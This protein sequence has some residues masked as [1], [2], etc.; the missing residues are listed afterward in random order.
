MK[1]IFQL[2]TLVFLSFSAISEACTG[3]KLTTK[4]GQS[5]HGRT[6][7]FGIMVDTSVVFVP[8]GTSFTAT[9]PLGKGLSYQSKYAAIGTICYEDLRIADGMNEQGLSVGTFY[10]PGFAGYTS[11][12]KENQSRS[13]SPLDFPNWIVTQFASLD[14]VKSSLKNVAIAPTVIKGWGNT[15][16]PFHYIVYDKNGDSIVIEPMNGEFIVQDNPL[17][18]LTNSP[19]FDWH[20]THLRNFINL[21]PKNVP[22]LN[23]NGITLAPFGQGSGMVGLPG[24]FTP[25]SRFVRAAIFSTTA[26]PSKDADEAV[27]QAFHILNQFDIPVGVAR[28]VE[29]GL[30]LS[31]YTLATVVHDPVH[32]KY[33]FKTYDDQSIRMV[34]LNAFDKQ[35]KEVKKVSTSGKQ[36]VMNISNTL[37]SNFR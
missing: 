10:F 8:Q 34:D 35:S 31:D 23:L 18:V 26:I 3:I 7:E 9:T 17:G 2:L 29:N 24:D 1:N 12:T 28:A 30:V 4:D 22:S 13:L 6:F 14:E 11:T 33:Y 37:K 25:P 16:P 27:F 20:M 5:I 19:T 15:S 21:T 32:L 36:P